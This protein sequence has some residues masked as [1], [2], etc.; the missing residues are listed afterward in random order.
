MCQLISLGRLGVG[1]GGGRRWIDERPL[2]HVSL[3]SGRENRRVGPYHARSTIS[4]T[5]PISRTAHNIT[6]A[7]KGTI[8]ISFSTIPEYIRVI[9]H[10][11]TLL[12]DSNTLRS[13]AWVLDI[14]PHSQQLLWAARTGINIK[15]WSSLF[16]R[17]TG[18]LRVCYYPSGVGTGITHTAVS[19]RCIFP[20]SE[21]GMF[22]YLD[23]RS[24]DAEHSL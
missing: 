23:I 6:H 5:Q 11:V 2:L 16:I 4:R 13:R 9:L 15:R 8:T 24:G 17:R 22:G 21:E 7:A 19:F 10:Q 18:L 12:Y 3:M 20:T 14:V 1:V